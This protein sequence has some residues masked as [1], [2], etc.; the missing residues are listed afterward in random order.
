MV[1]AK[2]PVK[3]KIIYPETDG[4]PMADGEFQAP[5]Y[6]RII[7]MLRTHF[8][9]RRRVRVNGD[10]L[11]YY[12]QGNR[13]RFVSPDCYVA[14]GLSDDALESIRRNNNYQ[15]WEVGWFPQ[16]IMEI[17]S[18][19]TAAYDQGGKLR[20]YE[21]LG[22]LEYWL[23]DSTG[24][25]FYDEPLAG[26]RLVNG[27]YVRM[28]MRYENDGSVWAHSDVLNLDLW[29]IDGELRFWDP[30]DRRWLLDLEES[31]EMVVAQAA[32]ADSESARAD[33]ESA[34]ADAAEERAKEELAGRLEA[35][36]RA[37]R[38]EAELR[39]LLGEDDDEEE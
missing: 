31:E 15:T 22:A 5:I 23:Y 7:T 2:A 8:R 4:M 33:S 26:N 3:T 9:R 19:S 14:L 38:L 25:E 37:A 32:R 20:L 36:A 13:H 12:S 11:I 16:F 21:S 34:R 6:A 10:T 24:G 39:R 18:R 35:E 17:G 28:E 30:V 29:W 27:E 1:V